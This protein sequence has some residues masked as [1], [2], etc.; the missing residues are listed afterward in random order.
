M[1][2]V[3]CLFFS[4]VKSDGVNGLPTFL[5]VEC[6][7]TDHAEV[8]IDVLFSDSTRDMLLV[9]PRSEDAPTVLKGTLKSSA[10]VKA[11]VILE[12]QFTQTTTVCVDC[13]IPDWD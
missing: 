6:A 3:A 8:C 11:V 5:R 7:T 1:W 12:D 10:D 2:H 13:D 4:D 9:S